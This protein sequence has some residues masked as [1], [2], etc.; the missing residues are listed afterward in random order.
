LHQCTVCAGAAESDYGIDSEVI[1]CDSM[2]DDTQQVST[3]ADV[4]S[5]SLGKI[6]FVQCSAGP[7]KSVPDVSLDAVFG[8]H[9]RN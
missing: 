8:M 2:M 5:Y 9:R 7:A 4:N 6:T 1:S 3:H